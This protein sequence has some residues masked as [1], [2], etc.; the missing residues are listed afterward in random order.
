MTCE[1]VELE[2]P[3]SIAAVLYNMDTL[4]E[5]QL[6]SLAR[7]RAKDVYREILSGVEYVTYEFHDNSKFTLGNNGYVGM[8][9]P[10]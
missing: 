2:Q 8:E 3:S 9:E 4:K 5:D 6:H 1:N 10:A 7:M